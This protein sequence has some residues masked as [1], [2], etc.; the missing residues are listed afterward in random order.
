MCI[1]HLA[2]RSCF[3]AIVSAHLL[4]LLLSFFLLLYNQHL[5]SRSVQSNLFFAPCEL[6]PAIAMITMA[7]WSIFNLIQ[8]S[9]GIQS[10]S[11]YCSTNPL[12]YLSICSCYQ[13]RCPA[14]DPHRR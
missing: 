13:I 6:T 8:P 12:L 2:N 3:A 7:F 4:L 5:I 1:S 9:C 14:D 11:N 10:R